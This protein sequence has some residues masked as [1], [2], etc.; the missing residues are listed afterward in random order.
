MKAKNKTAKRRKRMLLW[1][2]GIDDVTALARIIRKARPW[3]SD[4]LYGR[5]RSEPTRLAILKA[6]HDHG[7]EVE[8]EDLWPNNKHG[9]KAA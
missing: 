9:K 4:V 5:R 3:V 1:A 8:Y 2:A 7:I 6:L